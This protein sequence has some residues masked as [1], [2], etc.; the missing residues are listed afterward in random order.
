MSANDFFYYVV[1]VGF[2]AAVVVWIFLAVVA[3]RTLQDVRKILRDVGST[4][5]DINA[6]KDLIKFGVSSF[7]GILSAKA[8]GF[9][10]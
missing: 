6:F 3:M 10:K 1:A 8:R 5:G 7:G 4:T 2:L 9:G